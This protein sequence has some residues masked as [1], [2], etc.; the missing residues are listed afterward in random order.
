M[1]S[2]I[3]TSTR[4]LWSDWRFVRPQL[5][6]GPEF[7]AD[8]WHWF[9]LD[10]RQD[11]GSGVRCEGRRALRT[12]NFQSPTPNNDLVGSIFTE[13]YRR[14]LPAKI[15]FTETGT[16]IPAWNNFNAYS[17]IFAAGLQLPTY[18]RFSLNLNLVDNYLNQPAFGFKSN[19]LQFVTGV[20]YSLK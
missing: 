8:L 1:Q 3:S 9:G 7:A 6:P 17:A 15:I 16:F 13:A 5:L 18:R 20:T 4:T 19:S 2:T 14:T 12:A 10:D 11:T